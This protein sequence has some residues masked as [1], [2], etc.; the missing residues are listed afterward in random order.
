MPESQIRIIEASGVPS[1]DRDGLFRH[2][3]IWH[4]KLKL[5]GRWRQFSTKTSN[6]NEAKKSGTMR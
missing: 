2:R 6:Y 4:F 3:D 1:K 5:N